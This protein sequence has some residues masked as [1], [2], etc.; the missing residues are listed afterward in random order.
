MCMSNEM[1]T[2]LGNVIG[3]VKEVKID[4]TGECFGQ[5]LRLKISIDV[6]K[7]L[8]KIIELEQE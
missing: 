8:K 4:A 6:T 1:A 3:K 5:F 2:E 7:P